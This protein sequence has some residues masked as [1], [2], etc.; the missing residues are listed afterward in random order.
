MIGQG[1]LLHTL[2][3]IVNSESMPH[4]IILTGIFGSGRKTI[5]REVILPKFSDK[6]VWLSSVDTDSMRM[7]SKKA[8]ELHDTLFVIPD[9]DSMR[10]SAKNALL[11]VVEESPNNNYF[12]MTLENI[13]NTLTTLR[14]RAAVF[15]MLPYSSDELLVYAKSKYDDIMGW[16]ERDGVR[17]VCETPGDVD[18]LMTYDV[19]EFLDY[20]QLVIDN[21]DKV[22]GSNAFKIA[23]RVALQEDSSGYDLKLFLRAFMHFCVRE[24]MRESTSKSDIIKYGRWIKCTTRCLNDLYIT[25]IHKQSAFDI[26]ILEVR[27][28]WEQ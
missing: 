28:A 11:K 26:W 19:S 24:Y 20:V 1:E 4:F 8:Y 17:Y 9:A 25:G 13:E 22:S 18:L 15:S 3:L 2:G 21:I 5:I 12:I 10:P 27:A 14:S 16:K 7:I 6:C 23:E